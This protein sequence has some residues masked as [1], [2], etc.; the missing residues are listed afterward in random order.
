MLPLRRHVYIF[1]NKELT[2]NTSGSSASGVFFLPHA[3][4]GSQRTLAIFERTPEAAHRP[5]LFL[6]PRVRFAVAL[7]Q[8]SDMPMPSTTKKTATTPP[9][10]ADESPNDESAGESTGG[11][12]VRGDHQVRP[13]RR[14][15]R[16]WLFKVERITNRGERR[17]SE[18]RGELA[19][20]AKTKQLY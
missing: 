18:P 4:I 5:N 12:G 8:R 3:R 1:R 10:R 19:C 14:K 16:A 15:R 17:V 11:G 9:G 13:F 6:T 2:N 20:I 7:R